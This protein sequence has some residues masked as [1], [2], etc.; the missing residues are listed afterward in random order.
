MIPMDLY[1]QIHQIPMI[2]PSGKL[3]KAPRTW[4]A[5][6]PGQLLLWAGEAHA[7]PGY[8][9]IQKATENDPTISDLSIFIM[10]SECI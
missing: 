7:D 8:G 10:V 3:M 6:A 4:W 1:P 5:P 2:S 9:K